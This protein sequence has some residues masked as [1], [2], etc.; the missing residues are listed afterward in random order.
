[1]SYEDE[2]KKLTTD[3]IDGLIS[4]E[5]FKQEK[6]RLDVSKSEHRDSPIV[7][8]F[9]MQKEIHEEAE[10]LEAEG[11]VA[12]EDSFPYRR[13]TEPNAMLDER[14]ET[15]EKNANDD[16]NDTIKEIELLEQK[17]VNLEKEVKTSKALS[18][19]AVAVSVVAVLL[20]LVIPG[21]QGEQGLKGDRGQIGAVGPQGPQGKNGYSPRC[22]D[23]KVVR[24]VDSYYVYYTYVSA[25]Y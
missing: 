1:M 9:R 14:I 4:E 22:N 25:C 6:A 15:L 10:Q 16:F 18:G 8:H 5:Q 24:D 3:Y 2:L 20:S 12:V 7:D 13:L 11:G 21:P 19:W 17:M 23:I